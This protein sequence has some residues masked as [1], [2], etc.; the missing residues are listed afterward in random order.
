MDRFPEDAGRARHM[1]VIG[2]KAVCPNGHTVTFACILKQ[3]DIGTSIIIAEKDIE[4]TISPLDNIIKKN[5]YKNS[6]YI[7]YYSFEKNW[8]EK[9][10]RTNYNE[11]I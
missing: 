7:G 1:D 5:Q 6:M 11:I 8:L 9:R 4:P 2:H 10:N 3:G